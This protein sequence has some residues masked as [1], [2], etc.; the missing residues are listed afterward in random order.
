MTAATIAVR[1]VSAGDIAVLY[2]IA[3][4]VFDDPIIP[5]SA[6][7]FLKDPNA[8]LVVAVDT[9][10]GD[11]VIGFAS[12]MAHIH[13]D[14]E[15]P[16]LWINEVGVAPAYHRRGVGKAILKTLFEEARKAGC[17]LAWVATDD[18]NKAALALYN[19]AGGKPP[20]RQ[21]H[22]DFD[23]IKDA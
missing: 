3:P 2:H 6:E 12:A 18:D 14:K 10:K 9:A 17:A 7:A 19:A 13:P 16:E 21:I 8:F 1:L 22:I 4:E 11:L 20:E 5:S 23:L 15:R